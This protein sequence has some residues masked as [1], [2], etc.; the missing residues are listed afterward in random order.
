VASAG[1]DDVQVLRA[2]RRRGRSGRPR[3]TRGGAWPAG[4]QHRRCV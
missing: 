1:V 3:R 2:P 4:R